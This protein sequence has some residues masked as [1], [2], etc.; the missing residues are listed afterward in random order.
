MNNERLMKQIQFI[1]EIDKL[2]RI[3]RQN[4]VIG[5]AEN[6]NDAEHSWHMAVMAVL[7]PE[8]SKDKDIDVLKVIKLVL[9]HDIVEIDA[10]DT[11]C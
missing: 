5:T 1:T 9:V 7:L 3:L 11:F 6:E 2:K 8:Y 10:G 4:V